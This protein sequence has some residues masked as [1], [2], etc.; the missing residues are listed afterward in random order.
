[1]KLLNKNKT[2]I[3]DGAM[4]TMLQNSGLILGEHPESMSFRAPDAVEEIHRKYVEAGADIICANTFGANRRKLAGTGLNVQ[5]TV[6]RSVKLAKKAAEGT[7]TLVALDIGPIGELLMPYGTLSFEESIDIFAE[8]VIQGEKSGADIIFFETMTDLYELR[9]GVLAAK[10][11][12]DLPVFACMTFE[13]NM[14]TFGGNPI[15]SVVTVLEGLSVDALG[16]NCSLGPIELYPLVKRIMEYASIPVIVKPNAGLPNL[17]SNGYDMESAEFTR[18]MKKLHEL[19][20]SMTGGCCGTTPEFIRSLKQNLPADIAKRQKVKARSIICSGLKAVEIDNVRVIGERI[21][22]TGKKLFKEALK[23]NDIDYIV[24]Q[25]ISQVNAGA[26]ILDI[27]VGLPEIDEKEMMM[28]VVRGVQGVLDTPLQIDSSDPAVIE[29]ALRIYNG[30]ALVNSV[31]GEKA[32]MDRVLPIV[33]KYGGAVIGLT[34]NEKG[35]PPTWYGRFGIAKEIMDRCLEEGIKKQDIYIDCLTLTVSAQ[36]KEGLETLKCVEAVRE[37]LGLKTVLGVSNISFGLPYR[38][39]L[40][41]TFLALALE[42]GLN[43]PI[44]NPNSAD[45]METVHGF[46]VIHNYDENSADYIKNYGDYKKTVNTAVKQKKQIQS[47]E[48]GSKIFTAVLKGLE[49]E[50]RDYTRELTET[51]EPIDIINNHLIPALDEVGDKF[52]KGILF[53]PQLLKAANAAQ[54][55]FEVIKELMLSR[56]TEEVSKGKIVI[57]TVKGD[58]H[59]IGKNIVKVIMQNYGYEIIDLGKDVSKEMIVETV[60]NEQV[61]LVGLSAL[62]TTTLPSMEEA[63]QALKESAPEVK[64]FVGGAVLTEE[65]AMKI[66][67]DYYA[68]DAKAA[69]D[70]AK[71]I[72]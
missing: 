7:D 43:L 72:L 34:L 54:A 14:R 27:N 71:K 47:E 29:S 11:N 30:K 1:M 60:V 23:N 4:G 68:R 46:R 38:D 45:M 63:I 28:K 32:V 18:A 21:N 62:M 66:G 48:R 55:G 17:D 15:E 59:D 25:G 67:A 6:D 53:L 26:D 51:T 24:K 41:R 52:E 36:Q 42:R 65:Y 22:P 58:I 69:V 20:V 5:E 19:G 9:A 10:E 8:V 31:N 39:L 13:S 35:I 50:C 33:K 64:V 40:N 70:Y 44:I 2:I 37:N 16:V 61:R 12:T 49:N 3:L 57:A 56:G